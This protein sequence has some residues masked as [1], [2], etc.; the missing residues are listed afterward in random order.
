MSLFALDKTTCL[1]LAERL[2]TPCFIYDETMA[3]ASYESLQAVLPPRVRLAYAVKANHHDRL[4]RLLAGLGASFDC[5]SL[6]E[7]RRV[8]RMG[9]SIYFAG[10]AKRRHEIELGLQLGARF[11]VESLEEAKL[12]SQLADRRTPINLRVHLQGGIEERRGILGGCGPSAFGFDEEDLPEALAGIERLHHLEIRGLHVFS[13]SNE[14]DVDRLAMNHRAVLQLGRTLQE[15][16]GHDLE[17]IDLGGGLGIPYS[18]DERALNL[19][20]LGQ[21]LEDL[22]QSNPWFQGRLIV[23]PGRFLAGPCGT[24]LS[25]VVRVKESRGRRFVLLEAGINHLLRPL[26]TGQSFPVVS[27]NRSGALREA[28]L[29]GPLCTSL[30]RLGEVLLPELQP[31]DLLAFGQC[32]AYGRNEAMTHFLDHEPAFEYWHSSTEIVT[33][34]ARIA[35]LSIAI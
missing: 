12:L 21:H 10:P 9:A 24:Y 17:E 23:E 26:L 3:Q 5:A 7:L 13:A 28:I 6:G 16:L 15:N 30:D 8:S 18:V 32:G 4:L 22:L 27:C 20:S 1:D 25:R 19:E 34:P 31:G 2:P 14:L 35:P 11:Q 33:P 29:T